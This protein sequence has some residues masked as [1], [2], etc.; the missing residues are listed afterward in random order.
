MVEKSPIFKQI[1]Q[2]I[3]KF[4]K[5]CDLAGFNSD[6][7]D[8]PLLA[9]E[10][11]RSEIEFDIGKFKTIDV[12]TIFHKMEKRTLEAA[13]KF[14]CNKEMENAHSA[15]SDAE[16]AC[17]I[18]LAQLNF[19]KDL[20]NT[21]KFLSEFSTHKKFVDLA[22]FIVRDKDDVPTFSF[23]KHKGKSVEEV[24]KNQPGYFGWILNAD[25]P[26]YTKKVLTSMKL[27]KMNNKQ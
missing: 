26:L 17:D 13:Y 4:L 22:G 12:Q 27:K 8:I 14:Y 5:N 2:E 3:K 6:R 1:A 9:E 11:L 19:Y 18:L 20:D 16:A 15:I 24:L 10:F 25:F 23:G 21:V 7:F